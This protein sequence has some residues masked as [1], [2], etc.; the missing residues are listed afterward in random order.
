MIGIGVSPGIANGHIVKKQEVIATIEKKIIVAPEMEIQRLN[1]A[2]QKSSGQI[3][4]LLQKVMQDHRPAE[5]QIFEAH[6]AL[7]QDDAFFAEVEQKI[8]TENVN[9]EWALKAITD[10]YLKSFESCE[11]ELFR[12]RKADIMDVMNRISNV[13]MGIA[14]NSFGDLAENTVIVADDLTP[15]DFAKLD[16]AKIV[17]LVT[18]K[19]SRTSHVSIM[20][21]SFGVPAV[22]GVA[23]IWAKAENGAAILLDGEEGTVILNPLKSEVDAFQIKQKKLQEFDIKIKALKDCQ[24]VSKDGA[25]IEVAANIGAPKDVDDV[26]ENGGEGIGLYRTEFLF[27][28]RDWFPSEEEQFIAYKTVVE[29]MNGKPVVIRTLDIGGDKKLPYL[30]IPQED[31]PFLGYRAIRICLENPQIFHTQLRAILR[32]SKYGNLKIMFPMISSI[33]ELRAA[34][35]QLKSV[36]DELELGKIEFNKDIE[37]GM[38]VEIPAAAVMADIFA[39]EVDF[40]SIGTNDLIQYTIAVDRGNQKIAYLYNP[41]HPA[42][43]RFIQRTIDAAHRANI[44]VGI[45]GEAAADPKLAP[46][47]AAMGID[48]LSVN[49]KSILKIRWMIN[50]NSC[51]E[52]QKVVAEIMNMPTAEEIENYLHDKI[53]LSYE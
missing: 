10:I 50:N 12:E 17:G 19:G 36:R 44:W 23:D 32:A 24:T 31:N 9:A 25:K 49:S 16:F 47:F 21:R 51:R 3:E 15:S 5:A 42:V 37:V 6:K 34:K 33:E 28:D 14:E 52:M 20:A 11:D 18:E 26:L 39:K 53:N 27:L 7:V 45:C 46:V 22:V 48:E 43:L 40:F 29:K 4:Q 38:M 35:A 8:T 41:F 30:D 13:L 2:R 1:D